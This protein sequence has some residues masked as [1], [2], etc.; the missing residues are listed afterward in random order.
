[1][2][3]Y[4]A[5]SLC[6]NGL[7]G[8]GLIIDENTIT[9]KTGK[10]TADKKYSNLELSRN[11]IK[12]LS[13]KNWILLPAQKSRECIPCSGMFTAG[14]RKEESSA[15]HEHNLR[16]MHGKPESIITA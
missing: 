2:K 14:F 6:H 4:F 13:W 8:G 12:N 11:S 10:I 5:C 1:M 3:S 9:Y 16:C 7:L 15:E